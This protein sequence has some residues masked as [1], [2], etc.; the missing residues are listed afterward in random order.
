MQLQRNEQLIKDADIL[1]ASYCIVN[2]YTLVTRNAK[3]FERVDGLKFVNWY[4]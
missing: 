4:D 3:D 2:D 1:I